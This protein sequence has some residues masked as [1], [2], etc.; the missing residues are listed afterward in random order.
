M[1]AQCGTHRAREPERQRTQNWGFLALLRTQHAHTHRLILRIIRQFWKPFST[2]SSWP[3][4]SVSISLLSHTSRKDA[5]KI[6]MR[7]FSYMGMAATVAL[8]PDL[9]ERG[10]LCPS[11]F[12]LYS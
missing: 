5:K 7:K 6:Q 2:C 4:F 9:H 11:L 1:R 8:K 10:R 3:C 12:N